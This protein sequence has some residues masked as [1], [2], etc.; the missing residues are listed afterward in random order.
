M[1]KKALVFAAAAVFLLGIGCSSTSSPVSPDKDSQVSME[2]YFNSFDLSSPIVGE[3]TC[4]DF[5]GNV[6]ASGQLGRDGDEI[7][8]VNGRDAQFDIYILGFVNAQVTYNNPR[9]TIPSGPN[10]GLPYYWVGDTVDYDINI[11]SLACWNI[12]AIFPA[13]VTAEMHY[14]SWDINGDI[15]V[16]GLLPGDPVFTWNGVIPP[17]FTT[18]NDTFDIVSGTIP[19]L[20]VTTVKIHVPIF[21]GCL[22]II[23]FDGVAGIWDPQ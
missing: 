6:I 19:G 17:G 23:W 22:D 12:G 7:Y 14:A 18:L 21:C 16:G 2:D 5:E 4:T 11:T 9:G 10:A 8:V 1:I 20:D 15:V 13:E 3:F